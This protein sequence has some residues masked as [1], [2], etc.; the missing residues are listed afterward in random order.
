MRSG[1]DCD[2]IEAELQHLIRR[3]RRIQIDLHIR[4]L[5]DLADAVIAHPAPGGEA[6]QSAFLG[7]ASAQFRARFRQRNFIAA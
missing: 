1:R 7:D 3:Q 6:G 4:H 2:V 5:L